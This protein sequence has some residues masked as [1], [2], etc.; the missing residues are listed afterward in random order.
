ML[1][2]DDAS[3]RAMRRA[4]ETG[5]MAEMD[6]IRSLTAEI[7]LEDMLEGLLVPAAPV[8]IRA[9]LTPL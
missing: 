1:S 7:H 2:M 9:D 4:V 5:E 6:F 3:Y 8:Q